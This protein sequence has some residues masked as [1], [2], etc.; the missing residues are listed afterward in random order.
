M[1]SAEQCRHKQ[2]VL[3]WFRSRS[4]WEDVGALIKVRSERKCTTLVVQ[5]S[6][7]VVH[8]K[9][10]ALEMKQKINSSDESDY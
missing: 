2:L 3:C 7:H 8:T 9:C 1:V 10:T 4:D 6:V 5:Q